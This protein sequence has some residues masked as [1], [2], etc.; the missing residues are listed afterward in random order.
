MTGVQCYELFGG[1][2][3]KIT[4]FKAARALVHCQRYAL[5][6]MF[7][8]YYYIINARQSSESLGLSSKTNLS[9]SLTLSHFIVSFC[10]NLLLTK[11]PTD[12]KLS[13]II[14]SFFLGS[15]SY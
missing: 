11:N 2:S 1:I 14:H 3:L 7:N 6:Q 15:F 5:K 4:L 9:M 8:Y 12:N 13:V 10:R